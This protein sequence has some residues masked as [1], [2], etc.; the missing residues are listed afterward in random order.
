[1]PAVVALI[2]LVVTAV[3][4]LWIIF[5]AVMRLKQL[6]D[7]GQLTTAMKCIGYPTLAV[8]LVLDAAV[9]VVLGSL[10]FMELPREWTLSGRLW[11]LSNDP[12][13]GWRQRLALAL[14]SGLLDSVDPSGL[15]RG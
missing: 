10:A 3:W 15:H 5:V 7:A 4:A 12:A 2:L 6:R 1:M 8:G 14:R 9:N 13:E 11:R